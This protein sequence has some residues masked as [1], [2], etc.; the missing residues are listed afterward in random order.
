M[1]YS[2]T[3]PQSLADAIVKNLGKKVDYADIPID[4]AQKA[5]QFISKLL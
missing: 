3:T 4:G 5:A 2:K 1:D